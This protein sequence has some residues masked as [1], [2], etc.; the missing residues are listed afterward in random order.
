[1]AKFNASIWALIEDKELRRDLPARHPGSEEPRGRLPLGLEQVR[2]G[3]PPA[4]QF[5]SRQKTHEEVPQ[6][7]R[8]V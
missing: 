1:M 6:G 4:D 5:G 7:H 2:R 3:A 8:P